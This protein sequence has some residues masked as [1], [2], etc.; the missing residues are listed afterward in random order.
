[1]VSPEKYGQWAMVVGAAEGIGKA[2]S[3]KLAFLNFNVIL[4]DKKNE[5]CLQLVEELQKNHRIESKAFILDLGV[6]Q[7][8]EELIKE[9]QK[10]ACRLIV[11]NAAYGPVKPFLSNTKDEIDNYLNVNSRTLIHLIHGVA[12][13][14]K[15][16]NSG[17]VIMSSLA[18]LFGTQLV[19]PYA[20]TKAFDFN[21][22]EAL[23]HELKSW[24]IDVLSCCA[25]ATDTPNFR[26]TNPDLTIFPKPQVGS[27]S[28]VPKEAFKSLGRKPMHIVGF[29][30]RLNYF[31]LS[32]LLPRK[33]A[34][35]IFNQTMRKIYRNIT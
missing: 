11:Y 4:V 27:P 1:M 19:S 7:A 28:S 34:S 35:K 23:Y 21:L 15:G 20:A 16:K 2:F 26:D 30:N 18:G 32:R 12:P 3:E 13:N 9:T 10:Y 17:F 14:W 24:K 25:G 6:E 8:A 29:Q 31:I 22:G 33:M 5:S